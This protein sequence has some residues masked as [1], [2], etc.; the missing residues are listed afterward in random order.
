MTDEDCAELD[1]LF[2]DN[3]RMKKALTDI[4]TAP[5]AFVMKRNMYSKHNTGLLQGLNACASIAQN[6]LKENEDGRVEEETN[7]P[8][9]P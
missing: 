7:R 8:E 2:A 6:A 1:K 4:A 5:T 3:K 9:A